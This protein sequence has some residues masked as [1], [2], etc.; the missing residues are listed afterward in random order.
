MIEKS[1]INAETLG[2]NN[3]EFRVGD[4]EDIPAADKSAHVVIGNGV[5]SLTPNT[6]KAL[7]EAYRILKHH[8]RLCVSDIMVRGDMP[9]QLKM[10]ID[11]YTGSMAGSMNIDD[12]IAQLRNAG[13]EEI[14]VLE[15]NKVELPD[16]MLH[17]YLPPDEAM[18]FREGRS[19]AYGVVITA[20][21]PCCHAGEEDHV[22]CGNH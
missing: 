22:C 17:Y 6:D 16:A 10:D 3:V 9:S 7:A 5:L 15:E 20:E 4:V 19:G 13:F 2:Y 11:L 14:E 21:K 18:E 12:F 1:R 8:G